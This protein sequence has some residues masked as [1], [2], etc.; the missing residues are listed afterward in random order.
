MF[1]ILLS[2]MLGVIIGWNFHSFFLILETPNIIR[3]ELIRQEINLSQVKET[4][5]P[6]TIP[7]KLVSNCSSVQKDINKIII[8]VQRKKKNIEP[9]YDNLAQNHFSDAMAIYLNASEEKIPTYKIALKK[10]FTRYIEQEPQ[11]TIRKMLEYIELEPQHQSIKLQLSYFYTKRKDYPKAIELLTE[12]KEQSDI[13]ES[14]KINS[15]LFATSKTYLHYLK[16]M[17]KYEELIDFIEQQIEI[18]N[19]SSYFTL[20][21]A[22]YYIGVLNYTEAYKLLKEIEYD[23]TYGEK[24]KNL[25]EELYK[26]EA[27]NGL[28]KDLSY[29]QQ[30]EKSVKNY[31]N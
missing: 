9:F 28:S 5:P 12:L 2:L 1:N 20:V 29:K 8:P 23:H 17:E 16:H 27:V 3:N 15:I 13:Q 22:E 6:Q 24:S 21:L 14:E 10:Y 4:P 7:Q 25:L 11:N 26:K 19:H 30:V 18:E 31:E